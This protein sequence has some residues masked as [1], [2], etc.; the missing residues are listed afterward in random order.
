MLD[1][2][3]IGGGPIGLACGIEAA[4]KKLNYLI[5]EKGA[6]VN[7]I[8]NYPLFM[9]FFST[10]G[11][12]EIGNIPFTCIAPKP[13]RQ[14]AIEYYRN[15]AQRFSLNIHLYEKVNRVIKNGEHLFSVV[16]D[17]NTYQ[18]RHVVIATGF[19]DIPMLL[20]VPGE[21]LPK[22][23]HY[24]K[25]PHPYSFQK[26]LVVGASNSSVDAA[27]ETWRKGAEVTMVV[28]GPVI[29]ERV[30][31]WVKPDMENRIAEGSIKAFFNSKITAIREDEVAIE[32]SEGPIT[33]K[34]D[35]VL[36]LTG[37]RPD[38]EWLQ[39]CGV[40]L[41]DDGLMKPIYNPKTMETNVAGLYLAGVVCG[42]L[43]THKWFIE[44]SRVHA[45]MIIRSIMS[46]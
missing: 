36:A 46:E 30:K 12:L 22:V 17:K 45:E 19:Y 37:Y 28:R 23:L 44:N 18:A 33:I 42:G 15:V 43:E 16:S 26:L 34:N 21:A 4:Q 9:T 6:L 35:F 13:G 40:N 25:E 2:I 11:R 24:Y 3:I 32:T 1:L 14:D 41:S 38:L 31:Y 29:G 27:L 8:Y 5:L 7:S 10:A 20:N 39:Q